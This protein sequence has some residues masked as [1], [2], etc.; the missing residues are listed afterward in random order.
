MTGKGG[1][2]ARREGVNTAESRRRVKGNNKIQQSDS[3]NGER[4]HPIVR[5]EGKLTIR[6]SEKIIRNCI[7]SYYLNITL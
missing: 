6:M 7:I 4:V 3:G 5:E 2:S 1:S